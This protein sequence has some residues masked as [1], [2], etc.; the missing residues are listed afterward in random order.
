MIIDNAN[1]TVYLPYIQ[2]SH[3]KNILS[4]LFLFRRSVVIHLLAFQKV[5][6][7]PTH[8]SVSLAPVPLNPGLHWQVYPTKSEASLLHVALA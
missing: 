4:C 2:T 1:E 7:L 5:F 3:S 8:P 6:N